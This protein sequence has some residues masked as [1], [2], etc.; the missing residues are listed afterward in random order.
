MVEGGKD[1]HGEGCNKR[2]D[3]KKRAEQKNNTN[4][5]SSKRGTPKGAVHKSIRDPAKLLRGALES[6]PEKWVENLDCKTHEKGGGGPEESER[7]KQELEEFERK[8]MNQLIELSVN[9]EDGKPNIFHSMAKSKPTTPQ[10]KGLLHW[11]LLQQEHENLLTLEDGAGL[12]PM[13]YVHENHEFVNEV[14]HVEGLNIT[15]ILG[16]KSS[17]NTGTNCLQRATENAFPNLSYMIEKCVTNKEMFKCDEKSPEDTPLHIAVQKVLVPIR[18]DGEGPESDNETDQDEDNEDQ[19]SQQGLEDSQHLDTSEED[20]DGNSNVVDEVNPTSD[21]DQDSNRDS[22]EHDDDIYAQEYDEH[23][24][25]SEL[26][27]YRLER[28]EEQRERLSLILSLLDSDQEI[29]RPRPPSRPL[30]DKADVLQHEELED[31]QKIHQQRENSSPD[32]R[33]AGVQDIG[34]LPIDHSVRLLVG[35]FPEAL[36]C[37][38]KHGRTP[39]QEREHVLLNNKNV[40]GLVDEYAEKEGRRGDT[41]QTREARAK[42]A[43]VAQ[44]PIAYYI[45]SYCMRNSSHGR[46]Q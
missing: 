23:A 20:L 31:S 25:N 6:F 28:E 18:D 26:L 45:R 10:Q 1:K 32:S 3:R 14:M 22:E 5:T 27:G 35:A 11:M 2:P 37:K 44:D 9:S 41:K 4:I 12:T 39:Y 46:R 40:K 16:K 42:R 36:S 7:K 38:N 34:E 8:F 43:I 24:Q 33:I 15:N 17:K 21:S 30:H 29:T 13:H 19:Q